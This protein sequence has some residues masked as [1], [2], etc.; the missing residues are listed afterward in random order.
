MDRS[1]V[2]GFQTSITCSPRARGWT[3]NVGPNRGMVGR[4]PRVRG[5]GPFDYANR[6]RAAGVFPACAGMDR[7]PGKAT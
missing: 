1:P 6:I 4:V 3:V 7:K 2:S 5:D